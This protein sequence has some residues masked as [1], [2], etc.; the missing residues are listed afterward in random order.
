MY[1]SYS[2]ICGTGR[3]RTENQDNLYCGGWYREK[4]D[5]VAR[6]SGTLRGEAL[7]AVADGMGG[8]ANGALAS[9]ETVRHLDRVDRGG[10][11]EALTEYLLERNDALCQ[12][13]RQSGQRMGTT[14][15]GLLFWEQR[16]H[17]VN[18]GDS[19]VYLFRE[20]RLS[21][22]SH[23]HTAVRA[24]VDMGILSEE[25]ARTHRDRHRLSQHLGVFPEE[26][27]IEPYAVDGHPQEEDRFLLCSDG[28]TDMLEDRE[29]EAMLQQ[30]GSLRRLAGSLYDA[31]MARGGRDNTTVV[32]VRVH[33]RRGF[34]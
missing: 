1:F 31:A 30:G 27:V 6:R 28:L 3:V 9:L 2:A 14:F 4:A 18:I 29:I 17:V 33:S 7:F 15:A 34:L 23:D 25:A 21:Q 16:A 26:M 8:E 24:M 32:L 5:G 22:L 11:A 10:G 13:I 12:I 19:R 20:G